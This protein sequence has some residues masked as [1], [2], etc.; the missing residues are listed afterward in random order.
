[1][2]TIAKLTKQKDGGFIGTLSTITLTP[3]K[4]ALVPVE[5]D[6]E[7]APIY[8]VLLEGMEIGA[9]W[10]RESKKNGNEYTLVML[11]CPLFAKPVFSV[12]VKDVHSGYA[13][14]FNRPDSRKAK[15][16]EPAIQAA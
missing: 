2:T 3:R 10:K 11:D 16:A 13:L 9:A 15:K 8:R 7:K 5:S 4:I 6:S 14:E 1:M 12:L